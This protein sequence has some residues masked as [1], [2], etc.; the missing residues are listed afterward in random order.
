MS[1]FQYFHN[2]YFKRLLENCLLDKS[3]RGLLKKNTWNKKNIVKNI[4]I[5]QKD[6]K[7][8][9]TFQVQIFKAQ[10][11]SVKYRDYTV[12][13]NSSAFTINYVEYMLGNYHFKIYFRCI[14]TP[15]DTTMTNMLKATKTVS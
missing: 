11:H 14:Y 4:V 5:Y 10:P 15:Q 7:N 9:L 3:V 12:F 2:H 1:K 8:I 6:L 13:T